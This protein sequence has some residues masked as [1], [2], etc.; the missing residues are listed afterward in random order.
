[1]KRQILLLILSLSAMCACSD[2]DA[3]EKKGT[4]V[5]TLNING[6]A[7]LKAGVEVTDF[8]LRISDGATEMLK[9]RIGDLPE[10]IL[11]PEGSYIVEAYSA[12]FYV[13]KFETPVYSGK[14]TVE[15]EAGETKEAA[16][17]CSQSN[18]GIR[19]MWA[20]AFI[21]AYSAFQAQ[22]DCNA[23]YLNYSSME[24]RAGY[25]LPGTVSISVTADGQT[26]NCGSI[27]LAARDMVTATLRPKQTPSGNLSIDI[28]VDETV[29][30]R[31]VEITVDQGNA[32][33]NSE[34]NP[35]TIAEA[36]ARQGQGETDAWITGYIAGSKPSAGYDFTNSA[37]WQTT[38]IVLADEVAET[39]DAKCVFV[40]LGTG[41]IRAGLNLV[42]NPNNLYR[43]ILIKGNLSAY[44]TRAGLRNV[45]AYSFK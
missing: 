40:E 21:D 25:F 1:M 26:I 43:K 17:V 42:D 10:E 7:S 8:I 6:S 45:S 27:T 13:P 16:L 34:T 32:E 31:E 38:N 29:N 37:A 3:P 22:I 33:P 11:L 18:A 41:A 39:N 9:E 5:L 28:S 14:T 12:E 19:V 2:K 15:I 35:Y 23:G 4:G 30:S 44:F 24:T 20:S 36:V